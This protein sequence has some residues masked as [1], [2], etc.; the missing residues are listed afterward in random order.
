MKKLLLAILLATSTLTA[1]AV[2]PMP[3][4]ATVTTDG[5]AKVT[6]QIELL[7]LT[8]LA[9]EFATLGAKTVTITITATPTPGS[10]ITQ[11]EIDDPS[12]WQAVESVGRQA[13]RVG[14][15]LRVTRKDGK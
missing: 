15:E 11:A 12:L 13:R 2:E 8:T 1:S 9:P 5:G 3:Y 14:G 6:R 7:T 10:A 4:S